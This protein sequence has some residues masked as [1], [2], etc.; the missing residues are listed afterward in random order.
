MYV[1][2]NAESMECEIISYE[3]IKRGISNMFIYQAKSVY[4][5]TDGKSYSTRQSTKFKMQIY[6]K[7]EKVRIIHMK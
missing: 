2:L 1:K 3:R 4:F 5:D 6:F 7:Y